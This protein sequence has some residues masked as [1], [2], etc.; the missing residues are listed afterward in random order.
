MFTRTLLTLV[1]ATTSYASTTP[2]VEI[3]SPVDGSIVTGATMLRAKV[4]PSSLASSVMFF[5]DGIQVCTTTKPPFDCEWDAG[6]SIAAHHVR[7]VVTLSSGG[8][9][10]RNARTTEI[11][12]AETVDVDAVQVTVSV[13]DDRGRYVKGLPQSA[14]QI[15]EDGQPQKISQFY[16]EGAPLELVIAVDNSASIRPAIQTLKRSVSTFLAAVPPRDRVTLLGFNE[17]V[18]VIARRTADLTERLQAVERLTAWGSTVLYDGILLGAET[19]ESQPGRKA[20][21]V[22]T[23]GEDQ[24]SN[25]TFAEVERLLQGSDLALYMIGQ[26]QALTSKALTTLLERLS[27]PTG[28]RAFSTDSVSALDDAFRELLDELSNQYVLAYQPTNAARDD[29]WRE[30]TVTVDGHRQVRAR[31]GYRSSASR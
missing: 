27:R 5:A 7:L 12:F 3:L 25:A 26:G 2:Q 19:L 4:E 14:F 20:L 18:F 17:D 28:G 1:L 29:T 13:T 9:I 15:K 8:R 6:P 31:Q 22:F 21:V 30:I 10:V 11:A 16:A 24:G 23:D